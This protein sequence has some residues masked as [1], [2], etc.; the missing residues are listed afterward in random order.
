MKKGKVTITITVGLMCFILMFVM[1]M[2]FKTVEETDITS[3]KTMREAELRSELSTL[4]ANY[5][6][7]EEKLNEILQTIEEYKQTIENKEEAA[8]LLE[9]EL[10]SSELMAGK[11][12]VEGPGII[13]TLSNGQNESEKITA[14]D[15]L[16]LMNELKL[17]GAEAISI[18]EERIINMTDITDISSHIRVNKQRL[19][20]PFVVKA[21]GNQTYLESGIT[22]KGG[23][24][25][26]KID[27]GKS[28]KV[29][30]EKNIQIQK[31][32]EDIKLE[33]IP[34]N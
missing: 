27:E 33:T 7:T 15:L 21:I 5:A 29:E 9:K 23:Y 24:V 11:T 1:F 18:N 3:L 20:A 32:N 22:A 2:Q 19:T 10:Q 28:V 8:L 17:A 6:Q 30:K 14:I 25:D 13:V 34:I 26:E 31:Y 4:K 16:M 12:D